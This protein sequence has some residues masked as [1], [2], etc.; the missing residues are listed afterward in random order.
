MSPVVLYEDNH[1]LALNK[2]AGMPTQGDESGSESLVD[3][4]R[5][6]LR[7]RYQKPGN[8]FVGLVH[9]L[10]RPVSGVVLLGKTSKGA[11]RLSAQ[12][13]EGTVEKVYWA[14]VEG[15][16]KEEAGTWTDRLVKDESRNVVRVG[17]AGKDAVLAYRVLERWRGRSWLEVRPVS[18][19]SHQIRVQLASRRL[20]IV[21]DLKYGASGRLPANDGGHRIALHAR[22][23]RF[24][25]PTSA[26]ETQVVAP[27]PSDWPGPLS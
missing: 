15:G 8:V 17:A 4:A 27:V 7:V 11:S 3:W 9:R 23:L 13:R 25:H 14:I 2:P 5:E 10:D 16:P 1:C 26:A 19:R 20:P 22:S 21:G 6:D 24:R 18:G 12:F